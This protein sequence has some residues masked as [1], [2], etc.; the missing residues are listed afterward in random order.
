MSIVNIDD[1]R[2]GREKVSKKK[3]T[4]KCYKE[5]DETIVGG[6]VCMLMLLTHKISESFT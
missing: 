5:G 1:V 6:C 3:K 4:R 2:G